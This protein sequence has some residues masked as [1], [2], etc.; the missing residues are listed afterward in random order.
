MESKKSIS[1]RRLG[2]VV[3]FLSLLSIVFIFEYGTIE[4]WNTPIQIAGIISILVFVAGLV[5]TFFKTGLWEFT[6]KSLKK[7]DEREM[8]LTSKSL[9]VAYAVFTVIVLA[10]LLVIALTSVTI[11]IV[12]V[13]AL[14]LFAHLLPASIIAWTQKV[15]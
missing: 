10:I 6:H 15:V 11:N 7:L 4:Q 1:A 9:R 12:M 14:I 13:V 2:V 5:F 3:T 8:A